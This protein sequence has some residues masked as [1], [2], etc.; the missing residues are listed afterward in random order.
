M[1]FPCTSCGLCCQKIQEIKNNVESYKDIPT[2]YKAI[3]DF[4]YDT[5]QNGACLQLK[6]GLCSVYDDRPL[7]CNIKKLGEESGYDTLAWYKLNALS[8]NTLILDAE[9]DKSFLVEI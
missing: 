4:P 9:L 6:N 3:Q 1:D 2:M 8:C 5:D 7:L